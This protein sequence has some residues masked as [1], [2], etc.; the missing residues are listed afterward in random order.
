MRLVSKTAEESKVAVRNIRRDAND[1]LKKQQKDGE[2]T[3]DELRSATDDIQKLT[4]TYVAKIDEKAKQKE[5]EI[6]EV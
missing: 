4:D 3:E 1:E 5:Q 6:M 2:M